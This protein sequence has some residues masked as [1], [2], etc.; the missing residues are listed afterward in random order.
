MNDDS[1]ATYEITEYSHECCIVAESKLRNAEYHLQRA[2][3][4]LSGIAATLP[5]DGNYLD[6]PLTHLK[7]A[8]TK[9]GDARINVGV[10][11]TCA[12]KREG[13]IRP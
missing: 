7:T 4:W 8:H 11:K 9:I 12:T 3:D 2:V 13:K 10:V 6:H 5:E 1:E